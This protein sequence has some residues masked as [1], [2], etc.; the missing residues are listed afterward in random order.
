M[1]YSVHRLDLW[2]VFVH[3][4]SSLT[5]EP[6]CTVCLIF[7]FDVDLSL[8]HTKYRTKPIRH[9]L[10]LFNLYTY[11]RSASRSPGKKGANRVACLQYICEVRHGI[12]L[13]I[14]RDS[15]GVI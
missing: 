15:L 5:Q 13:V 9:I 6:R 10:S 11:Y 7:M 3:L 4:S 14:A 8:K 2:V 12:N 1:I